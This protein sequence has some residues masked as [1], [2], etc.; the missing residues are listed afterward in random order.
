MP[1]RQGPKLVLFDID[2]TLMITKGASSRCLTRAGERVVGP[3][4]IWPKI[5]P[6]QLDP[7]I[8]A[9]LIADN[10][11]E[12]SDALVEDFAEAYHSELESELNARQADITILPGIDELV[13]QLDQRAQQERDVAMGVLTG[14][15]RRATELKLTLS[16]L[17]TE[18]FEV[19]ICA[20]D[21][22]H[23]DELPAVAVR[24]FNEQSGTQVDPA[25]TF[26]IGDTPRDIQCA[27]ANGCQSIAVAT[28]RYAEDQLREAGG[29]WVF[30]DL[31]DTDTVMSLILQR[32]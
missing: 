1:E 25:H 32:P 2:G 13:Q 30:P 21:G 9:Q 22:N 15:S 5:T 4:F 18:R 19:I 29:Q 7:Q 12:P 24:Q 16:G 27:Q 14:N 8:I 10:G 6:G 28:G 3:H 17:G 31:S 26:I 11:A 23:R 20:E